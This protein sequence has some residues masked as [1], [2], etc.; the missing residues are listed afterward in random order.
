MVYV[1]AMRSTVDV[2]TGISTSKPRV[3]RATSKPAVLALLELINI[4][5]PTNLR[6]TYGLIELP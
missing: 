2:P 5:T 3:K 6:R 4:N 1:D